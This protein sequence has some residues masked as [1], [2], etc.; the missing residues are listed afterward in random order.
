MGTM[1]GSFSAGP[2]I[3]ALV[4][5]VFFV[6]GHVNDEQN[7]N[8]R[9]YFLMLTILCASVGVLGWILLKQ[10]PYEIG[11][12]HTTLIDS[13]N[14]ENE[15]PLIKSPHQVPDITGKALIKRFDFHFLFWTSSMCGGLQ[16]MYQ[17][18]ITAYL[19]SFDEEK[20]STLF[21]TL[22]PIAAVASKF[23]AGFVSDLLLNK[24]PRTAILLIYNIIQ[25]LVLILC[26][27]W[28]DNLVLMTSTVIVLGMANGA[29]WCLTPIILSE[30]F[31][32]KYFGRNW[33]SFMLGNA[34]S[35]IVLQEA[36]GWMYDS[37]I[38]FEGRTQCYG[39]QCF[40]WSFTTVAVLSF[41]SCIL[42]MGLVEK[43]IRKHKNRTIHIQTV[44]SVE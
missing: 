33:G 10:L 44:D 8:L 18:N 2:A 36:Y 22:N 7:Q 16:L 41:C 20:Y 31:G 17:N 1:D 11:P 28:G 37:S 23:F 32:L 3:L 9:G 21:T 13:E 4:Y 19:K 5:G 26:I 25:T 29:M 39:L 42:N 34:L 12:E 30:Y 24:L 38:P 35:G 14:V 6:N 15:V 27:F 40:K 43:D